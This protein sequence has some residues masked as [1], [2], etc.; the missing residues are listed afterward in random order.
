[1]CWGLFIPRIQWVSTKS[2]FCVE[3]LQ[4]KGEKG[5]VLA[6]VPRRRKCVKIWEHNPR[7]PTAKGPKGLEFVS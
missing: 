5:G 6:D 7:R 3:I 1:M 4:I 2:K